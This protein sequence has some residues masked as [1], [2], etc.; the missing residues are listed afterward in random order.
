MLN[1]DKVKSLQPSLQT[2]TNDYLDRFFQGILDKLYNDYVE[3]ENEKV[4]F[5]HSLYFQAKNFEENFL[6]EI[7]P[8]SLMRDVSFIIKFHASGN[9]TIEE[10]KEDGASCEYLYDYLERNGF[11]KDRDFYRDFY[12]SRKL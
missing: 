8:D 7:D 10:L 3:L 6:L 1:F 2:N 12:F 9:L 4:T 11:T 5:Y